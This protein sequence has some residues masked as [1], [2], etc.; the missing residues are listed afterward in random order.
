M[1]WALICYK[2]RIHSATNFSP[3]E[4]MF[5]RRMNGFLNFSEKNLLED[6]SNFNNALYARIMEIKDLA[7]NKQETAIINIEKSKI[8]QSK[9]QN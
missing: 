8:K 2:D 4:L 3:F 9:T 6:D 1:P 7:E 5:G